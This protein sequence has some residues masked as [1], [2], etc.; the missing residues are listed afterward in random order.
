[1]DPGTINKHLDTKAKS[2][3][4]RRNGQGVV[5]FDGKKEKTVILMLDQ[6]KKQTISDDLSFLDWE[7]TVATFPRLRA[8]ADCNGH[9]PITAACLKG[10]CLDR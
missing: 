10:G 9:E 3:K 2:E 4:K 6:T 5:N 1:M 7:M 8:H